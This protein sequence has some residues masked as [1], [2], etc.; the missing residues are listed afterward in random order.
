MSPT[1]GEKLGSFT[2]LGR[3]TGTPMVTS[4]TSPIRITPVPG[5]AGAGSDSRVVEGRRRSKEWVA[6][7]AQP[8][9]H[10]SDTSFVEVGTL[11]GLLLASRLVLGGLLVAG[12]AVKLSD[13][14][15]YREAVSRYRLVP[16]SLVPELAIAVSVSELILGMGMLLGFAVAVVAGLTALLLLSFTGAIVTVLRRGE[17]I[18]CGCFGDSSSLISW[19]TVTRNFGLIAVATTV[20]VFAARNGVGL[21][22]PLRSPSGGVLS[23]ADFAGVFL[24]A[25]L[26][27]CLWRLALVT[28]TFL[29]AYRRAGNTHG[30]EAS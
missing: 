4:W 21:W 28:G 23:G 29:R 11:Q 24:S 10:L 26:A 30:L 16:A 27:I 13:R 1:A 12:G 5:V 3:W 8:R 15:A 14:A 25:L 19:W 6:L 20:A 9:N 22:A 2:V 18:P 7:D 17:R